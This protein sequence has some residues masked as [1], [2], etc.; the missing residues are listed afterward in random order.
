MG[1]KW[2]VVEREYTD[3]E[4][5]LPVTIW[6]DGE[7]PYL[8]RYEVSNHGRVRASLAVHQKGSKP[9]RVLVQHLDDKGYP[10][11]RLWANRSHSLK[12][13][14]VVGEAFIA[15]PLS[16]YRL[17]INHIDG[18]KTHNHVLNLEYVTHAEN[19]RHSVKFIEK[20]GQVFWGEILSL[21][22]A[23]ERFAPPGVTRSVLTRRIHR[24]KWS[25][26]R[27]V[28]TPLLPAGR[29]RKDSH[30]Y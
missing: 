21:P 11:V 24:F 3:Q 2:S 9:G 17:V 26:E 12:V 10:N 19:S 29:Q 5:W 18:N 4:V 25:P 1:D 14:R 6:R 16:E 7:Q 23:V 20:C 13:H 28:T 27:A 15:R 22:E 8:N 30:V